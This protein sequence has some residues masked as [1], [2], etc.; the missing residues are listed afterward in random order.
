MENEDEIENLER[1]GKMIISKDTA[2][3]EIRGDTTNF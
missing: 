1:Y 2:K 3:V